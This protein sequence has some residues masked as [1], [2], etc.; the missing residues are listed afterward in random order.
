MEPWRTAIVS[1]DESQIRVRGYDVTSL[2]RQVSF[3]ETVFLLHQGRL[4]TKEEG[5]LLDAILISVADH[6]PGAPSAAAARLVASGNRESVSCAIAAG[7]LAIGDH[8][9][10]AGLACMEMIANGLER[11]RAESISIVEAASRIAADTKANHRRLPGLGHRYHSHDPRTDAL[12]AMAREGGLARDGVAF[13][14][15]L[16]EAVKQTIKPLPINVDGGLAAVLFDL[17][18]P[19]LFA[20]LVFIIGRVAGLSAEVSEELEREKPMRIRIPVAYDGAPP[21]ELEAEKAA[22]KADR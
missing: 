3:A 4:P 9:G 18:F 11:A 21:R 1:S 7:V 12:F 22:L 14:L 20:R 17:G 10:G 8:H 6:G 19:A 16:E 15:A 2:M 13:M 5:R